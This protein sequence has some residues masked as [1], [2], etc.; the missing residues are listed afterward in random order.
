MENSGAR[1]ASTTVWNPPAATWAAFK[2]AGTID[3]PKCGHAVAAALLPAPHA[4]T[5]L[6]APKT[7]EW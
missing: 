4:T 1:C 7:T 6:A 3:C 5:W 2:S